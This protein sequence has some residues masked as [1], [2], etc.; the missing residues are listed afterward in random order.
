M[1]TII[2]AATAALTFAAV[3]ALAADPVSV[4][5]N[6]ENFAVEYGSD[7]NTYG[8][9]TI[10]TQGT[11]ENM[12]IIREGGTAQPRR[13]AVPFGSGESFHIEYR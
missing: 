5:R 3:P 4:V 12:V 13:V 1:K 2:L 7:A 10:R 11:G 8:G 6:G 9:G